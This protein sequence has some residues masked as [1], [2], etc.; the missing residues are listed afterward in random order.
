MP[1]VEV[2][3]PPLHQVGVVDFPQDLGPELAV[4]QWLQSVQDGVLLPVVLPLVGLVEGLDRVLQDGLHPR[5]PLLPQPLGDA[6]HRVVGAVPVGEDAGVQQVDAGSA[7]FVGQVDELHPVHQGLGHLGQ[8]ALHQVGVGVYDDDGVAVPARRLLPELVGD[9]VLH[10]GGLAHAGPG[11]VEVVAVEQVIGEVDLAGDAAGGVA[12]RGAGPDA[13]GRG[14][15]RP[16]A[17]P[18]H[19]GRLVALPRRVPQGGRLPDAQDAALAEQPRSGRVQ[20]GSGQDG[21]DAADPELGSS[22]VVVV[23]VGCG[24]SAM[25]VVAMTWSSASKATRETFSLMIRGS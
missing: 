4:G 10:Q 17:G 18:L 25:G 1:V 14:G 13:P 15:Q 7:G 16:G 19:Q 5:P 23:A 24:L 3:R 22:G 20:V 21:I 11:H 8:D 6:H 12:H 2:P 9:Y